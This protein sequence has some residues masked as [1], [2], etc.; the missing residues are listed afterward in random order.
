MQG[1]VRLGGV[2][3]RD[4]AFADLRGRVGMVTQDVQLFQ[5]SIRDNLAMFDRTIDGARIERALAELGLL[6]WV[7]GLPDGLDTQ[8]GEGGVGLSAGEVQLLAFAR[9]LLSE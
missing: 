5:A 2:D 3:I 4:L 8:L 6:D 1:A 9:V 7:R